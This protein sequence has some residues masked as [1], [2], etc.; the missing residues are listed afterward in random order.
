MRDSKP[1]RCVQHHKLLKVTQNAINRDKHINEA[2][3]H[4]FANNLFE[5][6]CKYTQGMVFNRNSCV[7]RTINN[8]SRPSLLSISLVQPPNRML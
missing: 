1:Q 4:T 3:K 6:L 8:A 2:S 5:I 7:T